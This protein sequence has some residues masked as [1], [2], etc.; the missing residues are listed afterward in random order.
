MPG[1]LVADELGLGKTFTSMVV[2]SICK[3]LTEKVIAGFPLPIWWGS[4]L[5][6]WVIMLQND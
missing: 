6:K 2:A 4:T 5:D 1:A 3:V